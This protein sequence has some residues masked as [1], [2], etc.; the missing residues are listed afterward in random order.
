MI[1][2]LNTTYGQK[3]D[4]PTS[5]LSTLV[6]TDTLTPVNFSDLRFRVHSKGPTDVKRVQQC[7]VTTLSIHVGTLR[8][9][10][11]WDLQTWTKED[12]K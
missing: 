9:R 4:P 3:R 12:L 10:S 8:G 1:V 5:D 2:T 7:V 11:L 6:Y